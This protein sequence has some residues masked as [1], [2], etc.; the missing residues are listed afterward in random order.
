MAV[1]AKLAPAVSP[2]VKT[3]V[4]KPAGTRIGLNMMK[5][6]VLMANATAVPASVK[7]A[8]PIKITEATEAIITLITSNNGMRKENI[9]R[10]ENTLPYSF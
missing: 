9:L 10:I 1:D 5:T 4:A 3:A 2:V 8:K 7:P 6:G